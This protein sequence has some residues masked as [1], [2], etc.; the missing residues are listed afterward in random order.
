MYQSN[1][2]LLIVLLCALLYAYST[3]NESMIAGRNRCLT[4]EEKCEAWRDTKFFNEYFTPSEQIRC[5]MYQ[6]TYP[7]T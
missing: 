6:Q 4:F 3:G 2:I 7:Q 1:K 5:L